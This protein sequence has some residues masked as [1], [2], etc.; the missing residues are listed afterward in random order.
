MPN[1]IEPV[2]IFS[3]QDN[4]VTTTEGSI[5]SRLTCEG[6]RFFV[7][8]RHHI[9]AAGDSG[10]WGR[11]QWTR[12][13]GTVDTRQRTVESSL[14]KTLENYS[15]EKERVAVTLMFEKP[16][17]LLGCTTL[18]KR[19][20][21][22]INKRHRMSAD[23]RISHPSIWMSFMKHFRVLWSNS[24]ACW[25]HVYQL[26][27]HTRQRNLESSPQRMKVWQM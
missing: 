24:K 6:R 5:I 13:E 2:T 26:S 18:G 14:Q 7:L 11:G 20:G 10:H 4:T 15:L 3:H 22:Y 21:V 16:K 19:S 9:L 12:R 25:C 8:Q 1:K 17:L 23:D 27:N